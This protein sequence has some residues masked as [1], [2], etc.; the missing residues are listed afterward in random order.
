MTRL[1][2]V[3]GIVVVTSAGSAA[4]NVKNV[5]VIADRDSSIHEVFIDTLKQDDSIRQIIKVIDT[6]EFVNPANNE[7][8]AGV[9]LLMPVGVSALQAVTNTESTLPV[10]AALV[11]KRSYD[12]LIQ[13][14]TSDARYSA[15]FIDQPLSRRFELLKLALPTAE[16]IGVLVG[17]S[18]D[19]AVQALLDA[20]AKR[21]FD[22]I[23]RRVADE[24]DA[25]TQTQ[26][27]GE[28]VDALLAVPDR[29]SLNLNNAKGILLSA[30]RQRLPIVGYTRAYVSAGALAA[31]YSTPEQIARHISEELTMLVADK[32]IK[33][34]LHYP[35][36][37]SVAVNTQV[38][39]SLGIQLPSQNALLNQLQEM[40]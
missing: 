5:L 13:H 2:V 31:V 34:D 30:Y 35:K 40:E 18:T 9:R 32:Q 20:A 10:W 29:V 8:L 19:V 28:T 7:F 37:Y 12:A 27:I 22:L 3:L 39:R 4:D 24:Q 25:I 15:W 11:P 21:S 23:V 1:L 16:R 14:A 33:P 6:S 26:K 36:Y 17:E 38:A